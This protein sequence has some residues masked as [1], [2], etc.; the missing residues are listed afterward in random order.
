MTNQELANYE[1][2]KTFHIQTIQLFSPF[3]NINFFDN[4]GFF[5]IRTFPDYTLQPAD[6]P[7]GGLN[8]YKRVVIIFM[9]ESGTLQ[10]LVVKIIITALYM[11]PGGEGCQGGRWTAQG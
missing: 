2:L 9:F 10:H 3:K 8:P 5:N 4:A 7:G 6:D 1:P 11:G